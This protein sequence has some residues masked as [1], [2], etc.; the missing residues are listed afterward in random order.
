MNSNIKINSQSA[1]KYGSVIILKTLNFTVSNTV[2]ANSNLIRLNYKTFGSASKGYWYS[3]GSFTTSSANGHLY[4]TGGNSFSTAFVYLYYKTVSLSAGTISINF[5]GDGAY[6]YITS[7][8][9]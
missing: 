6:G 5:S 4:F 9:I 8:D 7:G 2:A 1:Y 3:N